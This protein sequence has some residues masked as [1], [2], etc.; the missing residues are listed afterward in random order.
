MCYKC[1]INPAET[2]LMICIE[3]W[4]KQKAG[5]N[6][7]SQKNAPAL[8]ELWNKQD[9]K[10]AISGRTLVIG[11]NVSLDHIVP[12]SKGGSNK[13]ANLQWTL[14]SVNS[15]K[16]GETSEEYIELCRDIVSFNKSKL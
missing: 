4:F 10:C 13:V 1:T 14:T 12:K 15:G 3:C 16:L 2:Y 6:T 8:K 5:A 11:L 9:G 7:G